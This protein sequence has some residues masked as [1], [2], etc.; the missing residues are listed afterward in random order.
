MVCISHGSPGNRTSRMNMDVQKVFYFEGLSGIITE[1]K[2]SHDLLSANWR[3]RK[4]SGIV[5]VQ[6]QRP[7]NQGSQ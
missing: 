3:P 6:T 4:A 1:P 2:K 7:E 5:P